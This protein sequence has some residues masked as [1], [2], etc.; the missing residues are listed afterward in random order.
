MKNTKRILSLILGLALVISMFSAM[1]LTASAATCKHR[2]TEH[3]VV[4]PTCSR[5]GKEYDL[6]KKCGAELN[7]K[8]LMQTGHDW[9]EVA[10]AKKATCTEFGI[11]AWA[12]SKC[13]TVETVQVGATGHNPAP[14]VAMT[15]AP[16]CTTPGQN[17]TVCLNCG[18]SLHAPIAPL[19]H[20]LV[21]GVCVR[22]GKR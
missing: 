17:S 15:L 19:G 18:E 9:H 22:C 12:C 10:V 13:G 7:V 3:V 21:N 16:T 4:A 20:Q 6:C 5:A 8:T 2:K 14:R 11:A 1:A